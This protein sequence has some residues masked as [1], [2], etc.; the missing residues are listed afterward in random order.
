MEN[1]IVMC[2]GGSDSMFLLNHIATLYNT[3]K[4][5]CIYIN[6]GISKNS[7]DW[8]ETVKKRAGQYNN[9]VPM[10]F[11]VLWH[12]NEIKNETACREKRYEIINQ[13]AL[14]NNV[15]RIFTG[16]HKDDLV[17]N[18]LISILK[19]RIYNFKMKDKIIIEFIFN[20]EVVKISYEKPLLKYK[21]S[22]IITYCIE[23]NIQY[24]EDESNNVSDNIRNIIRNNFLNDL[25]NLNHG[26][27]YIQSMNNFFNHYNEVNDYFV[28]KMDEIISKIVIK[29]KGFGQFRYKID[30]SMIEDDV[31]FMC[32]LIKR[33]CFLYSNKKDFSTKAD[34]NL[35]G[36]YMRIKASK[37]MFKL[38]EYVSIRF[39]VNGDLLIFMKD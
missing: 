31:Y 4:I 39:D 34:V 29:D 5:Y 26:E 12:N 22:E 21:K 35:N 24:V 16:H 2:S 9:V 25:R 32:E 36:N 13:F 15:Q 33:V 3:S 28:K 17:E 37:T 18:N 23:N 14:E 27:Q 6:H 19:N 20:N 7:N 8:Y 10:M 38:N 30:V 1:L 11:S